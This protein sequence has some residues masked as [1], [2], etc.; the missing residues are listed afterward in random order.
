MVDN[1]VE[2]NSAE[3]SLDIWLEHLDYPEPTLQEEVVRVEEKIKNYTSTSLKG[4]P[5]P[6]E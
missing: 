4:I 5:G 6:I 2:L 1:R 3:T